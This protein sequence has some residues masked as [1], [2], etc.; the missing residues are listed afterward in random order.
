MGSG[1]VSTARYFGV[2]VNF[3][4]I[5]FWCGHSFYENL[6]N[7]KWP[8][9]GPKMADGVWKEANPRYF[10]VPVNFC[11]IGSLLE[12]GEKEKRLVKIAVRLHG[13]QST[14]WTATDSNADAR[15]NWISHFGVASCQFGYLGAILGLSR[16]LQAS[17]DIDIDIDMN[18]FFSEPILFFKLLIP[19]KCLR[20]GL[21][22]NDVIPKVGRDC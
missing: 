20:S 16:L 4:W 15:A 3:C 2:P 19:L 12:Q 17:I 22:I 21:Y 7:L 1:K 6:K 11:Q 10:G 18:S 13:C 9:V 5:S 8:S 14:P